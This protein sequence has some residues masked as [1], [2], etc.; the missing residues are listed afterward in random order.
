MSVNVNLGLEDHKFL[1]WSYD[2]FIN[3]IKNF[4]IA[5][6]IK[7]NECKNPTASYV[8]TW[9]R[10]GFVWSH[11]SQEILEFDVSSSKF[12]FSVWTSND[13]LHFLVFESENYELMNI[14]KIIPP[15]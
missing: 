2:E 12:L 6:L 7:I 9:W 13:V 5:E 10:T 14:R 8:Q 11:S 3:K 1:K 4:Q 15:R